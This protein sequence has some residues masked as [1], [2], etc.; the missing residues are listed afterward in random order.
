MIF[1]LQR[2]LWLWSCLLHCWCWPSML[3][4]F[5]IYFCNQVFKPLT[6]EIVWSNFLFKCCICF[7]T[8][9]NFIGY[10]GI[11]RFRTESQSQWSL[12][13][14]GK[15]FEG[16]ICQR[17]Y[18]SLPACW[19]SL[20]EEVFAWDLN[21]SPCNC[22]GT[23]AWSLIYSSSLVKPFLLLALSALF[24]LFILK[25]NHND[26]DSGMYLSFFPSLYNIYWLIPADW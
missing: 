26:N 23:S 17:L 24:T 9:L 5:L 19:C 15:R 10:K 21:G 14:S 20:W 6:R 16:G 22:E 8:K 3:C 11:G 13:I 25:K 1:V 12:S 18:I 2:E 7:I 4:V